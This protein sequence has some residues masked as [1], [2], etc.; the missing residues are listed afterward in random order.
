MPAN[1]INFDLPER[2]RPAP[3]DPLQEFLKKNS[4]RPVS[5]NVA[6]LRRLDTLVVQLLMVAARDWR[7]RGLDFT[8][9]GLRP[10]LAEALDL[11]GVTGDL[12]D[13]GMTA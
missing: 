4:T 13:R 12:L 5:I 7:Q 1:L 9:I 8:L 6:A 2:Y 11:I 10:D 3:G